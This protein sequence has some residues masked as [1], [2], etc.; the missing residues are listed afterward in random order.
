ML[1][2][3]EQMSSTRK[4]KRHGTELSEHFV[5][6]FEGKALLGFRDAG[7]DFSQAFHTV[8]RKVDGHSGGINDPS[9]HSF[10]C[11]P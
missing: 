9:Q 11:A 4:G 7:K 2:Q 5:P 3:A 10:D 6:F 1:H 8:I